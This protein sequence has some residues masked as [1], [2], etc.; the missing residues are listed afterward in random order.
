M[1]LRV[2]TTTKDLT[3]FLTAGQVFQQ[4]W[5]SI[6]KTTAG[7]GDNVIIIYKNGCELSKKEEEEE[8]AMSL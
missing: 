4:N 8:E 1:L 7:A 3:L 2:T 5:E 6:A